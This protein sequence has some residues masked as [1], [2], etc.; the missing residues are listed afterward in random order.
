VKL[1]DTLGKK[2]ENLKADIEEF[3]TNRKIKNARDLY[4]GNNDF[5]KCY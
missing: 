5:K 3:E 4:K 2:K 1:V